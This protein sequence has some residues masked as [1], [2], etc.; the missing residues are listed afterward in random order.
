[1]DKLAGLSL[2]QIAFFIER[3]NQELAGIY[4]RLER[5]RA[6]IADAMDHMDAAYRILSGK[7]EGEQE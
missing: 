3:L 5:E 2:E 4:I 7:Q 6:N 1:M